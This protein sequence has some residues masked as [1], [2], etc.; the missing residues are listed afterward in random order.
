MIGGTLAEV[1]EVTVPYDTS[2]PRGPYSSSAEARGDVTTPSCRLAQ[3]GHSQTHNDA[4][5]NSLV[6]ADDF[7]VLIDEDVMWPADA[8]VVDLICAVAELDDTVDEAS[9][10][11]SQRGFRRRIR[12]RSADDRPRSWGVVRRDLTVPL[13]RRR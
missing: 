1:C 6:G 2:A 7:E 9:L 3:D 5:R 12:L 13:R 4:T 10:V 8:D 11:G